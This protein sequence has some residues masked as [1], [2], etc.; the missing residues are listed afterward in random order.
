MLIHHADRGMM[1]FQD[2]ALKDAIQADTTLRPSFA[3][4]ALVHLGGDIGQSIARIQASLFI[5]HKD[6]VR[7]LVYDCAT[8]RLREAA[9]G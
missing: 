9:A 1:T 2:D 3:M 7:G 4:E 8:G 6:D 5:L